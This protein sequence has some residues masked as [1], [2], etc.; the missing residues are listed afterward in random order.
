MER[1]TNY[2][3]RGGKGCEESKRVD[4]SFISTARCCGGVL[5][6]YCFTCVQDMTGWRW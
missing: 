5:K 2:E 1:S 4:L 3:E 6:E